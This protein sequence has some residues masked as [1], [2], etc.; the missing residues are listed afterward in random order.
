[1]RDVVGGPV[2]GVTGVRPP[3][4]PVPFRG[5]LRQ[6]RQ[7]A[8]SRPAPAR[9]L[10]RVP[11]NVPGLRPNVTR[12]R[13]DAAVVPT[14]PAVAAPRSV[15]KQALVR[16]IHRAS[17]SAGIEPALSVAIARAESS[18]NPA[19]RSPDGKSV[20]TFQVTHETKAEMHRKIARGT[21]D[22]PPGSDDVALGVGY[23]R[24]LHDLFGRD[25]RL[26]KGLSTVA[27][28][29]TGERRLFAVAAYNCGEGRVAR[30]QARAEQAG[31]DPTQFADVKP[32]LP[33]ITQTYVDRVTR[34]TSEES[35]AVA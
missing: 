5:L 4:T 23:L 34:Y 24:Y 29:D 3:P 21:V 12:P 17:S 30:A 6:L 20:G 33:P 22:R 8:P 15:D 2:P 35:R 10:P 31:L 7:A 25:A 14:T 16:D 18:L 13:R 19:A 26:G 1:M 32:F 28:D 27:I 11:A 9:A